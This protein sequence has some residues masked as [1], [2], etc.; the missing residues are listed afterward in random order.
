MRAVEKVALATNSAMLRLVRSFLAT[1]GIR[2]LIWPLERPRCFGR[3]A[4]QRAI[5][6]PSVGRASA[7]REGWPARGTCDSP[8]PDHPRSAQYLRAPKNQ[9]YQFDSRRLWRR[10]RPD[11]APV[12][13]LGRNP[14]GLARRVGS[15]AP[16]IAPVCSRP[17]RPGARDCSSSVCEFL[18]WIRK[19]E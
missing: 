8:A 15:E 3:P 19:R 13:R 18:Y 1:L 12:T 5:D 4:G 2:L 16:R 17:A 7:I 6:H 11:A 10:L 9:I 14:A